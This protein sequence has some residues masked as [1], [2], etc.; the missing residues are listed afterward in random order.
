MKSKGIL[1][2]LGIPFLFALILLLPYLHGY[3]QFADD[4]TYGVLPVFQLQARILHEGMWPFWNPNVGFGM[5][6]SV[7]TNSGLY[8]PIQTLWGYL[9]GWSQTQYVLYVLL[10]LGLGGFW[11]V[12]FGKR[13]GLSHWAS[14]FFAIAYIG[15]GF[16]FGL[17]Q[18][19]ILFVPYLYWPLLGMGLSDVVQKPEQVLKNVFMIASSLY[20]IEVIGYPLVKFFMFLSTGLLFFSLLKDSNPKLRI[21]QHKTL[22]IAS[23]A[24]ILASA[25]EWVTTFEGL[26]LS[27]R[28]GTDFYDQSLFHNIS[29]FV[30]LGSALLPSQFLTRDKPQLGIM[31]LERSW[32]IGSL[33]LALIFIGIAR[34]KLSFRGSG[35]ATGICA[36]ALLFAL[37]GNSFF[38]ELFSVTVPIFGQM[39]Q[40]HLARILVIALLCF[41]GG[42]VFTELEKSKAASPKNSSGRISAA[43]L[44]FLVL[45]AIFA[46]TEKDN[47]VDPRKFYLDPSVGWKADT[48]HTLFYLLVA[49]TAYSK[50]YLISKK[51]GW[52]AALVLIQFLSMA[53]AGY[54]FRHVVAEYHEK[55]L[56]TEQAF[57]LETPVANTRSMKNW[58]D[59]EDWYAWDGNL[60]ALNANVSPRH[61]DFAEASNDPVSRQLGPTLVSC[62]VGTAETAPTHSCE[63]ENFQIDYYFGNRIRVHG[64]GQKS[65]FM[66]FHDFYDP[67]FVAELNGKPAP[68]LQV[69]KYFKAV[70][71][72]AGDWSI[73]LEYVHP[74]FPALWIVAL[75]GVALLLASPKLASV[76]KLS[77]KARSPKRELTRT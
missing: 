47:N 37:G 54:A 40:S 19:Q 25:P 46:V 7:L 66:L 49:Y 73:K 13:V 43:W 36:L 75:L 71:V 51:L 31:Q 34:G 44:G 35:L 59:G 20:V 52:P 2:E 21:L 32:W 30:Q 63:G 41:L 4:A 65:A 70:E 53:D 45:C 12:R 11:A 55:P 72:P 6:W 15:N 18:N 29:N 14:L 64:S 27:E 68:V 67:N 16:V 77:A 38:R 57:H 9:L 76:P 48:L 56:R 10:H 61:K 8:Y 23:V 26:R 50:R 42:V 24:A 33:T 60:K 1:S 69:M 5:P 17:I 39:R 62:E 74:L 28:M 3:W 22:A 58:F